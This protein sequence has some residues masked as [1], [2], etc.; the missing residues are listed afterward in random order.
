MFL[1]NHKEPAQPKDKEKLKGF[2]KLTNFFA[3]VLEMKF[4]SRSSG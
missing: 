2:Q 1:V 4:I 3:H